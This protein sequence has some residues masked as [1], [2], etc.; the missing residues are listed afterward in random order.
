MTRPVMEVSE[1]YTIHYARKA[2]CRNGLWPVCKAVMVVMDGSNSSGKEENT[3]HGVECVCSKSLQ[4][5]IHYSLTSITNARSASLA[6]TSG[7]N[8]SPA[9]KPPFGHGARAGSADFLAV[10]VPRRTKRAAAAHA[11]KPSQ[12]QCFS[13][14]HVR[15]T[16]PLNR[17]YTQLPNNINDLRLLPTAVIPKFHGN[18]NGMRGTRGGEPAHARAPRGAPDPTALPNSKPKARAAGRVAH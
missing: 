12:D 16:G 8:A 17:R 6:G 4:T 9:C 7:C 2:L 3:A 10:R 5:P 11:I 15:L 1:H 18:L 13:A 14:A